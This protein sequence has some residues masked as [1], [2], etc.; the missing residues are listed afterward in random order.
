M[1][2]SLL[3]YGAGI[4]SCRK[5]ARAFAERFNVPVCLTW[6]AAD[7]LPFNHPLRVGTFGTHG[8]KAANLAIHHATE[9]ICIG[10]RLD[11]KATGYPVSSFAPNAKLT[12][13]DV[14]AT[15]IYKMAQLGRPVDRAVI[16]DAKAF[17]NTFLGRFYAAETWHDEIAAWKEECPLP[18]TQPY[19]IVKELSDVIAPDD[20]IVCDTGCSLAWMMQ[21]YPFKGERF[22]HPFNQTP[23]GCALGSAVGAAFA[24]GKKVWVITGDGGLSLGIAEMATIAKHKLPITIVLLNNYG[25]AMCRQSERQWLDS[26]YCG[27]AE[28][29]LATPDFVEIARAYGVDLIEYKINPTLGVEGQIKF[30]EP[31]VTA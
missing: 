19:R 13:V 6:G 29:D 11:T 31:L 1:S 3:I 9:I 10:S 28:Q 21:A 20:V 2:K 7:L 4:Q 5:E 27:T 14:D 12:M 25:H 17:M 24:T 26:E 18:S 22:I 30:G 16:G 8:N 23:M 15:E